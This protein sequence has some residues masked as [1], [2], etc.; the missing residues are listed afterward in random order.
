MDCKSTKKLTWFLKTMK[1][2]ISLRNQKLP[3]MTSTLGW[4]NQ[5]K[6]KRLSI[7][8]VKYLG[9]LLSEL[10]LFSFQLLTSQWL[11]RCTNTLCSGLP[12]F[13][14]VRLITQ[15]KVQIITSESRTWMIISLWTSMKTFAEVCLKDTNWCFHSRSHLTSWLGMTKWTQ[16]S[17][18]SFSLALPENVRLCL[19]QPLGLAILNGVKPTGRSSPC[20][21]LMHSKVLRNSSLRTK[22]SFRQYLIQKNL[23]TNRFQVHGMKN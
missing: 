2:S 14:E 11:I 13:M 4:R 9:Q 7:L 10:R 20:L 15:L 5:L 12:I 23:K 1:W 19:T 8:H 22:R 6:K 21:T 18:D 16:M 17:F 3:Q